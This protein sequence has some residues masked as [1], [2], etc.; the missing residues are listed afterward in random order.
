MKF[1]SKQ[2]EDLI[3]IVRCLEKMLPINGYNYI[4]LLKKYITDN[5]KILSSKITS[6]YLVENKKTYKRDKES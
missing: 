4:S 5:D 2:M 3:K 6:L 1:F